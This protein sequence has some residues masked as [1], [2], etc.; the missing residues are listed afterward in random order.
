MKTQTIRILDVFLI[1]PLMVYIADKSENVNP[2]LKNLLSFFGFSTIL[3]NAYNY[4][5]KEEKL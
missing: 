4:I 2:V 5:K 1:G 3:Y